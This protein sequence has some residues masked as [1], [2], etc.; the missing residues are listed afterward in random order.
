MTVTERLAALRTL[1]KEQGLAAYYVPSTDPHASEYVA[2]VWQRRAFISGFNGSAGTVVVTADKAGL[3]TDSRYFLQAESQLAGSGI[4]LHRM[5]DP[6]VLEV[7]TWL[8]QNLSPSQQVGLDAR[9]VTA[10]AFDGLRGALSPAG[11]VLTPVHQDLVAQIWGAETPAM[12]QA[13]LRVHGLDVAG[14]TVASKLALVRQAMSADCA[15]AYVVASL[16]EVAWLTNLRGGD[17]AFNPVFIG[18]VVVEKTRA[19]LFVE[20]GKVTAEV[21]K[22]LGTD[23]VLRPYEELDLSLHEICLKK[24]RVL[25]DPATVNQAIVENLQKFGADVLRKTGPIPALKG[26]KNTAEIAGM[27]AAH[28]RD[29]PG[30]GSSCWPG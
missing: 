20:L 14:A 30:H 8:A 25:V 26:A 28:F 19:T 3:W 5:G 16:D 23:I 27:R 22:A 15:D 13:P 21:R 2:D 29:G 24:V 10:W 11:I 1:M 9:S 7:E 17:V 18:Y 4:T 12:P 6:G